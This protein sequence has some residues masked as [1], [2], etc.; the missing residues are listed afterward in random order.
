MTSNQPQLDDKRVYVTE[1][2]RSFIQFRLDLTRTSPKTVSQPPPFT[3]NNARFPVE[4]RCR[5]ERKGGGVVTSAEYALGSSC[6]AEQVH[7]RENI[8]HDPPADMCLVASRDEFLV[9]KSWDRNQRGVMLHPPTLGEQPE[10]QAGRWAEAFTNLRIDF[11]HVP[12]EL[13]T[14]E[15]DIV[16][17]VLGNRP[18]I[19]QTEFVGPSGEC[20]YLEYPVK[21]VNAG[22][23]EMFYQVDTGPV[24]IPD[25]AAHDGKHDISALRL[26]FIAHNS[27]GC[28]ELLVSVPTQIGHG[29]SVDHYSQVVKVAA[30]NRMIALDA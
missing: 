12:G 17:A 13:M 6:K 29:V 7:V 2:S 20:V 5:V 21:V 8:W 25:A 28:T 10:R 11:A 3:L 22:E 1:F 19:S 16:A 14:R 30:K 4:C 24:L 23:R 27:L 9:I 26:A 18:L 15:K